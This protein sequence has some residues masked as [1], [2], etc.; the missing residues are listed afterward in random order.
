M[1]AKE[2]ITKKLMPD[3]EG[4]DFLVAF[5]VA[6]VVKNLPAMQESRVQSVSWQ[7]P[8]VRKWQPTPAFLPGESHGQRS[9]VSYSPWGRRESDSTEQLTLTQLSSEKATCLQRRSKPHPRSFVS[10]PASNL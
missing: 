6:Q 8:L 3:K 7:D 1:Q 9:L 10:E 5:V 4:K 2:N